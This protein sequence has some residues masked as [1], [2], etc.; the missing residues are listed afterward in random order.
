MPKYLRTGAILIALLLLGCDS[1]KWMNLFVPEEATQAGK[2]FVEDI[3]TGNFAPVETAIDP[4]YKAQLD[5]ALL[6]GLQG[7]F[8]GS[9]IRSVKIIGSHA[10][11]T[12][13]YTR[14]SITYEYEL[15]RKW[16]VAEIV[17]QPSGR[18][19]QIEGIHAQQIRQ[20]VEQIN[21]FTLSG[22][23][24]VHLIFL[25]LAILLPVFVLWTAIV[26]WRTPIP[27]RKWIWRIFVLLGITV[28][29]LNWSSGAVQFN[30]LQFNIF[31]AGFTKQFYAPLMLQ[32]G[33]PIGAVLF[34][35]R[36]RTWLNTAP[37][38]TG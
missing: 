15:T 28:F 14:Y 24:A 33:L 32:V 20:S 29:T 16:L 25:C 5:T 36:R 30:P 3:R 12:P 7:L 34:W 8:E 10:L 18:S 11:K 9:E 1:Q 19:F 22:K 4:I 6:R 31:A 27:R 23:S 26:C 17:L 2:T 35:V 38:D 37:G 21:A 13:A